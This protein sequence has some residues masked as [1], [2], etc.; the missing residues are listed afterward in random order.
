MSTILSR[1]RSRVIEEIHNYK[2]ILNRSKK[3][4]VEYHD[5]EEFHNKLDYINKEYGDKLI[6]LR[7]Q[8]YDMLLN[9]KKKFF[10]HMLDCNLLECFFSIYKLDLDVSLYNISTVCAIFPCTETQYIDNE[11]LINYSI[12]TH[13]ND[14][15]YVYIEH[16]NKTTTNE[17]YTYNQFIKILLY[18]DDF[19]ILNYKSYFIPDYMNNTNNNRIN[20]SRQVDIKGYINV[21]MYKYTK[22]Y[23]IDT[24]SQ[25]DVNFKFNI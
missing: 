21:I 13:I 7:N 3:R 10:I 19:N 8:C 1:K 18:H 15:N 22:K 17:F 4:K 20:N 23:L 16:E 11:L 6:F 12:I 9:N 5:N 14:N 24:K 2:H 25:C